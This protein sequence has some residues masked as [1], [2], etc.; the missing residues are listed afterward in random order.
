MHPGNTGLGKQTILNLAPHKP[1]HVWLAARTP[2]KAEAAIAELKQ[3]CPDLHISF[4]Q[5]DLT[6]LSSVAAAA[7]TFCAASP[8]LDVL[9]CNAGIMA[10]P[11]AETHDGY[12]IQLGTN[13]I[14][15]FLL[16]K[17]LLPTLQATA[18]EPGADVRVVV[19][20]SE[21]LRMVWS[22]AALCDDAK[23]K[24]LGPWPAYAQSKLANALFARE[25]ARRF[26]EITA[27]AL[28]PGIIRTDLFGP[29]QQ[30]SVFIRMGMRFFGGM[31][32]DVETGA[33]NQT[34]AA[35]CPKAELQNGGYYTPIGQLSSG[36]GLSRN[37]DLARR[38]WEW[39]E[40][41]MEEKG[42]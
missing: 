35:T 14:G 19:L 32:A 40:A 23:T 27:V 6:D 7:R 38:L 39:S 17:L 34:W 9:L 11:R 31:W 18:K 8:R 1:A 26:P 12:E 28:H 21:A 5:L 13:H 16:T 37:E 42:Y 15:H 33:K 22:D 36:T 3:A 2:S 4:L 20:T 41:E 25:L 30:T 29:Q 10:V 24:A